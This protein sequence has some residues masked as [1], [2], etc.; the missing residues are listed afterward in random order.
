METPPQFQHPQ[1]FQA[2]KGE[3][4][5]KRVRKEEDEEEEDEGEEE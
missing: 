5:I 4:W 2:E 1:F 3:R